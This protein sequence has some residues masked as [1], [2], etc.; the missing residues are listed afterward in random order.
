MRSNPTV[1]T[2]ARARAL[3]RRLAL[4]TTAL[5]VSFFVLL[6]C[7]GE[8]TAPQRNTERFARGLTFNPVFPQGLSLFKAADFTF[9]RVHVV[10][11]RLD[12]SVALDTT[13]AF[14]AN[15]TEVSITLDVRLLP[16][17]PVTGERLMLEVQYLNVQQE[18]FRGGVEIV[19]TPTVPGA[20]APPPVS[21][22]DVNLVYTGPGAS[23]T[24]VRISPRTLAVNTGAPFS[25]TA[26]ATDA[27]G[28]VVPNTPVA[29]STLD[30]TRATIT[31]PTAGAGVALNQ[32]GTARIVAQLVGGQKDTVTLTVLPVAT[33]MAAVSGGGQTGIVGKPVTAPLAQPIVVRV[34]AAD[35]LGVAGTTV[36]FAAG[37]GGSVSPSSAVTDANGL[38]QA[39]WTLGP[40]AG[41]QTATASVAGVSGSPVT[42]SATA[43]A[44]VPT[45]LAFIT[46][47]AA[48]SAVSAGAPI[49]LAVVAQDAAG[50]P[51]VSFTGPVTLSLGGGAATASLGGT[52]TVN[53]VAGVAT[54]AN[55]NIAAPG[56]NYVISASSSGLTGA[57]TPAFSVVA[58]P[59]ANLQVLSGSAQTAAAGSVLAPIT[60]LL[61]DAN[62]NA[63]SSTVIFFAVTSGGGS[64]SPAT[65]P[66]DAQGRATV[67][68][69]LGAT[70]GPQT[71]SASSVGVTTL[72]VPATAF[73]PVRH[74]VVTTNPGNGV[75]GT[76]LA[77]AV[78]A[79]LRDATNALVT[80]YNGSA[81]IALASNPSSATL[82]GTT[83]V[84]AVNGV[85]TFPGLSIQKAAQG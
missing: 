37:N 44:T 16:G 30:P 59:A 52:T 61:T 49:A 65:A 82:G 64:V 67:T 76:A 74:W 7:V 68:W 36:N 14:P 8:P 85:A 55:V 70:V 28:T 81:S 10:L 19:A 54:F 56:T 38:A 31:S 79:E 73:S 13:V 24:V 3:V 2:A 9:D 21:V 6:S 60:V 23:A 15:A 35:G 83:T 42:F 51:V 4:G 33:A 22:P 43:Q 77:P 66:T 57:S 25:F 53:A 50:D 41:T 29:W 11:R 72:S 39:S 75:A 27:S 32:R 62:G 69:T 26:T 1:V 78:V 84:T 48:S 58:G 18:I 5:F 12:G 47:P 71:I 45:K 20:P 34:T 17:S 40:I 46:A 80:S 63:K